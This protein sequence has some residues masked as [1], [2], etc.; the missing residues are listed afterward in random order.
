MLVISTLLLSILLVAL[1]LGIEDF[2]K[3]EIYG[4]LILVGI[5][6][7]YLVGQLIQSLI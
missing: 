7:S 3:E 1:A 5:P 4:A 2:D 6:W